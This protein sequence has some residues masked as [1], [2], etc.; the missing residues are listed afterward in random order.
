M[1]AFQTFLYYVTGTVDNK[2]YLLAWCKM[3]QVQFFTATPCEIEK[4]FYPLCLNNF[5]HNV[6]NSNLKIVPRS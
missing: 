3:L 6:C 2:I 5:S 1:P 4:E